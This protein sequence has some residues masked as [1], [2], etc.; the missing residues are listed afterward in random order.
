MKADNPDAPITAAAVAG[1]WAEASPKGS[2]LD[3]AACERLAARIDLI[4]GHD[5]PMDRRAPKQ[6]AAEARRVLLGS[7]PGQLAYWHQ[8]AQE[9]DQRD[10][11]PAAAIARLEALQAALEAVAEDWLAPNGQT[12]VRVALGWHTAAIALFPQAL[13]EWKGAGN[14]YGQPHPKDPVCAFIAIALAEIGM[15]RV[16][17]G[18]VFQVVRDALAK[19]QIALIGWKL[20]FSALDK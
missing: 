19:G 20:F 2:A 16:S 9:G 15:K 13:R 4:R 11:T 7:I 12:V 6:P 8:R 3:E 5:R 18:A 10:G 17:A 1:W 14:R